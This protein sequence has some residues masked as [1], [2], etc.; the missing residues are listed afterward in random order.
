MT[1]YLVQSFIGHILCCYGSYNLGQN[2][3]DIF[4]CIFQSFKKF[5]QSRVN[6]QN[7]VSLVRPL[8]LYPHPPNQ[9]CRST[10]ILK[11]LTTQLQHWKWGKREETAFSLTNGKVS[12]LILSEIVWEGISG[13][14]SY[15]SQLKFSAIL[16]IL[17]KT[18]EAFRKI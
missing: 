8:S 11:F 7:F 2:C 9:C 13:K 15:F 10:C 4:V 16:F 17:N 5:S 14:I 3:W 12:H 18:L 6:L 1:S